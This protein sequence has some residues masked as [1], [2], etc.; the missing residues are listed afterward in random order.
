MVHSPTER[1]RSDGSRSQ[2]RSMPP[3]KTPHPYRHQQV[4]D[5]ND[6]YEQ[7]EETE[8][9]CDRAT[10][11]MYNMIM[12]HQ[13]NQPL[14]PVSS[15]SRASVVTRKGMAPSLPHFPSPSVS[16]SDISDYGEVFELDFE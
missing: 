9:M 6:E 11:R 13:L 12:D 16:P 3:L 5:D 2:T 10:W 15:S 7:I 14:T 4:M 8:R 1:Q